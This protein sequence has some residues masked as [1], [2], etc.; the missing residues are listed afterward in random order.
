MDIVREWTE[1]TRNGVPGKW[2]CAHIKEGRTYFIIDY[3]KLPEE[4]KWEAMLIKA[5]KDGMT[6]AQDWFNGTVFF[7]SPWEMPFAEV[8]EEARKAV[9]NYN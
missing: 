7:M 8:L 4:S 6:R 3:C 5:D 9:I 1:T 2:K